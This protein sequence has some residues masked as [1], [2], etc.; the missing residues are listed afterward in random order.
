VFS[1]WVSVIAPFV[2]DIAEDGRSLGTTEQNRIMLPPG[3]HKLTFSHKDL[4][5]SGTQTV[6][7][8]PGGVRS[9]TI[10]PRGT[11]NL[12]AT[13]WAEIWL[14]GKKLG[15]TPLASAPVPLG[16]HEF[17]FKHPQLGERRVTA[18][19]RANETSTVSADFTK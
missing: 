7:I 5:Y 8:E 19:I 2:L 13:P 11:A 18:T 14:D 12:N 3:R 16:T 1:G 6:D 15:D 4:G 9:V 10:D 17:V